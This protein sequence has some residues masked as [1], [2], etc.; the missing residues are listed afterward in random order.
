MTQLPLVDYVVRGNA[1][2]RLDRVRIVGVQHILGTT[3]SMIRSLYRL[4]LKPENVSLLGKCYSTNVEVMAEMRDEGIDVSEGSTAYCSYTPY[5][6]LFEMLVDEFVRTRSSNFADFDRVVILDDGGHLIES[7]YNQSLVGCNV[8]CIEQTSSGHNSIEKMKLEVPVISVAKCDAK[9]LYETPMIVSAVKR[10]LLGR[11][12]NI[13]RTSRRCVVIGGG[14]L[15]RAIANGLR[16]RFKTSIYDILPERSEIASTEFLQ[17]LSQADLV[18]GCTGV[19][20]IGHE[21]HDHLRSGVTLVSASSSDRE[22]D[23]VYLRRQAPKNTNCHLDL[24][25]GKILLLNSGFPINFVGERHSV[26]PHSIQ[27]TRALLAGSLLQAASMSSS[28]L[29]GLVPLSGELQVSVVREYLASGYSGQFQ[30][31]KRIARLFQRFK[32]RKSSGVHQL[33]TF[34]H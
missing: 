16:D 22:F 5:D 25:A 30:L 19:T 3:H 29:S 7:A 2:I 20:S 12:H 33:L 4:G 6:Q 21:L 8:I 1:S 15:G 13:S 27:L 32:K 17:H 11:L 28:G 31:R 10:A 26:P 24:Q 18:I 9:S 14:T 23:A 34:P